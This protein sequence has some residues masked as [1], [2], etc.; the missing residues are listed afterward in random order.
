M[1]HV[2]LEHMPALELQPDFYTVLDVPKHATQMMIREAYVRRKATYTENNP[3]FYSLGLDSNR[4]ESLL[5]V[6][7]AYAVLMDPDKREGYNQE[8]IQKNFFVK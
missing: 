3:A 6:E 2:E 4:Q 5:E 8:L 1:E 7:R